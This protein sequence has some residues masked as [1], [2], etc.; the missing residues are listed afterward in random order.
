MILMTTYHIHRRAVVKE[1]QVQVLKGNLF[2][3]NLSLL[4]YLKVFFKEL[5]C[6]CM[7]QVYSTITSFA[8][9]LHTESNT[10]ELGGR[11]AINLITL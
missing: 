9:L 8:V 3:Q 7:L 6:G 5:G 10:S 2:L 11:R 1:C 4:H